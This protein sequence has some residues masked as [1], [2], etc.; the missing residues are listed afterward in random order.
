M[1]CDNRAPMKTHPSVVTKVLAGLATVFSLL[2]LSA[3]G[4]DA[5]QPVT[6]LV[7]A[8]VI[9]G[10]GAAPH[11]GWTVLVQGERIIA[12]GPKVKIPKDATRVDLTGKTLLPGL[13]DM[14][15]HMY[16]RVAGKIKDV[17]ESYPLLFLAGGVTSIRS[18]GDLDPDGMYAL[19]EKVARGEVPGP[20]IF[21]GGYYIDNEP[22]QIGWF[23]PVKSAEEA[24]ARVEEW[25]NR[26]DV[27][28]FYTSVT[29]D[30]MK[31]G[32]AAAKAAGI[33]TTGHLGSITAGHAIDLGINGLEHGI[34]AMS[35]LGAPNP[36][37]QEG[38]P[39][40]KL[41]VDGPQVTALIDKIVKNHVAIDPTFV[42][43]FLGL[44]EM[45]EPMTPDWLDYFAEGDARTG[46]QK[47]MQSMAAK[48]GEALDC[49]M[50]SRDNALKFVG[51]VQARGGIILTGTDPVA[52]NLLPGW[53][54][55]REM[56][57]LTQAGLTPLQAIR[58]ATYNAATVL[59][60]DKD[61][62]SIAKGKFADMV[63]VNGD[64]SKRIEDIGNTVMVFKEGKRFDPAEL[65]AAAKGKL[66]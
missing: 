62:G 56:K 57:Y 34:Y 54:L 50:R 60:R 33:P 10:T 40:G 48:E 47:L 3:A 36:K 25:K 53:A 4:A 14:H 30:E 12:A 16:A 58:A 17:F 32:I 1:E 19:K 2:T 5:A 23:K 63:V 29:E 20:R 6:A 65:R 18:P 49:A 66:Q 35:E 27:V 39:L 51:K 43:L 9:D 37:K 31:A 38:C 13:I 22:S 41:E 61:F 26:I 42:V 55:H 7:G 11:E 59:H 8:R 15:G 28:K 44:P 52:P 46:A 64:P 45:M 24:K 21:M